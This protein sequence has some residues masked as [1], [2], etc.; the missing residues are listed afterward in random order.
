MF[1][2]TICTGTGPSTKF[3]V[4][5]KGGGVS[6]LKLGLIISSKNKLKNADPFLGRHF[7]FE[8]S[9]LICPEIT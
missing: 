7:V 6:T 8:L 3:G 9:N 4:T 2:L 5:T 1:G